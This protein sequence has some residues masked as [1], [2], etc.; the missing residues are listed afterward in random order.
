MNVMTSPASAKVHPLDIILVEDDDADAK[1]V[2]RALEKSCI[3]NPVRRLKDGVDALAF[4]RG[5]APTKPPPQ[6]IILLDLNMPRMNGIEFLEAL[7]NDPKLHRAIVF[8]LTTSSDQRDIGNAYDHNVA[9]YILK[10]DAGFDFIKL[11]GTLDHFWHVVE[12]P[13]IPAGGGR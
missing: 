5:E 6:Y 9:G 4:L 8:V 12:L 13:E 11:V 1:A 3:A 2:R 7:R 10:D